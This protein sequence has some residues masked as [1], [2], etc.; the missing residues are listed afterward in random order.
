MKVLITGTSSGI[1]KETAEYFLMHGH[2][3]IGIDRRTTTIKDSMYQH[4]VADVRNKDS[5]PYYADIDILVNNAGTVDP[6]ESIDTNLRGYINVTEKY[7][8]QKNIK[9]V[10]NVC[11]LSARAGLENGYYSASQGGRVA[12]SRHLAMVL[13]KKYGATVNCISPGAVLTKLEPD[14]YSNPTLVKAIAE[15]NILKKWIMPYEIAQWIYFIAV[16]NKSMTGQDILIDAGEEAN[17]N[18]ISTE[19]KA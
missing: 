19:E 8:F 5:L 3:V 7:A 10:V 18:F 12:Y 11:S 4:W 13:G 14:I 15:E 1:G 6:E 2:E 9:A 17:Y 16:T